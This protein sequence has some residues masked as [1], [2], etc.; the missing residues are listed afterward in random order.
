MTVS[1]SPSSGYNL[2]YTLTAAV[3]SGSATLGAMTA[4]T[5]SLAPSGSQACTV[6]ATS[7]TLGVTTIS[8]TGS[9]PNAS[10]SPQTTTA[11]LTV[12]GHSNPALGVA[13]GN[14]QSVFKGV[15]G[16]AATL[17]LTD[18]GTNL[19]PLDVNTLSSGLSGST[20]TA[21]IPCGGSGSYIA[22]L[23]TAAAGLS[24]SQSFSLKAGDEQALSGANALGT[25][26]QSITGLNVYNHAAGALEWLAT[27]T[28][29]PVIVGYGS[30]VSSNALTVTNT[31]ASPGGVLKTT[32]STSLGNV[33]L[34][35]VGNVAAGGGTAVA[36]RHLS[37]RPGR[38][39][40][41]AKWRHADLRRRLD[42][43]RRAAAIWARPP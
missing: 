30:P 7:T 10:N 32:G 16:I 1:N 2:N 15:A 13:S 19:S 29:P 26:T 6:S 17:S 20:G 42:L 25:L 35:N 24:Q 33:T 43:L 37:F 27:L 3:L 11:T 38:G 41:H 8:F 23:S 18:S 9:D 12:L 36:V 14:N 22:A 4:G 40:L 34:N 28:I 21:V 31:A 39:G 5:G